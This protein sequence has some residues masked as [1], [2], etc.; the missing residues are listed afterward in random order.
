ML[1]TPHRAGL[2]Y[3]HVSQQGPA[4]QAGKRAVKTRDRPHALHPGRVDR[5][6]AFPRRQEALGDAAPG[7]ARPV[8]PTTRNCTCNN[9]WLDRGSL[10]YFS[11][12]ICGRSALSDAVEPSSF[13]FEFQVTR[14][15]DRFF[16]AL[17]INN[18]KLLGD[19][20]IMIGVPVLAYALIVVWGYT[21]ADRGWL[22]QGQ[23]L[24]RHCGSC[25]GIFSRVTWPSVP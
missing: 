22:T 4:R 7:K 2:D 24:H 23:R 15:E 10:L 3:I 1:Q 16:R 12:F 20:R 8:R 6:P 25:W 18:L 21:A 19:Q 11:D 14:A 5:Q 13:H 9:L 17:A